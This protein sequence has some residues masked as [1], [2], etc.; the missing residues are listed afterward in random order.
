MTIKKRYRQT[1]GTIVEALFTDDMRQVAINN[2][3]MRMWA[4]VD[5]EVLDFHQDTA[6][7]QAA[8]KQVHTA[9]KEQYAREVAYDKADTRGIIVDKR[10]GTI[11]REEPLFERISEPTT[12]KEEPTWLVEDPRKRRR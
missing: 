12:V 4:P 3:D 2:G 6:A 9:K 5:Q 11:T 7:E 1:D 10:A 8:K